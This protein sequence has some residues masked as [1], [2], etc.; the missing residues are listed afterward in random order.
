MGHSE[1]GDTG[2]AGVE[3]QTLQFVQAINNYFIDD[4]T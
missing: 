4:L 2:E 1:G 3:K